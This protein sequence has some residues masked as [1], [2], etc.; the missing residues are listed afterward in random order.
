MRRC[1]R[2]SS[3]A[4]CAT[5]RC[6]P[7]PAPICRT[8]RDSNHMTASCSPAR[9]STSTTRR[10]RSG[11][12]SSSCG[13]CSRRVRPPSARAG[14]S[15]SG[16]SRR[17]AMCAAIRAAARSALPATSRRPMPGASTRCS[18]GARRPMTSRRPTSTSSPCRRRI[19]R[20]WPEIAWPRSRRPRSASAARRC[21]RAVPSRV[22]ARRD[23]ND[24]R[25]PPAAAVDEGF[26]PTLEA[27]SAYVAELKTLHA[28]PA[29]RDLAWRHGLDDEVLDPVR[30]TAEIRSFIAH[31]VEPEKS[32]RGRA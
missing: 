2:R 3:R 6:R 10:L 13:R 24:H 21:G 17:A 9:R 15:R 18:P 28:D 23:R 19:A 25:P 5:S 26:F 14:A 20:C 27:G 32:R 4:S 8:R 12:R 11:A 7:T 1:C 29:R 31:R 22:H 16:R 30:R